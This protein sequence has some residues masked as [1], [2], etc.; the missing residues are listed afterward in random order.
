MQMQ[1]N[2]NHA[3]ETYCP[4][5]HTFMI[6]RVIMNANVKVHGIESKV[7]MNI[8]AAD[9]AGDVES[10]MYDCNVTIYITH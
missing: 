2:V 5:C 9:T 1:C 4:Q 6:H 8:N 7:A 10:T 3:N